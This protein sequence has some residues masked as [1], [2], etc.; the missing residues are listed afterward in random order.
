MIERQSCF[1]QLSSAYTKVHQNADFNVKFILFGG[2]GMPQTSVLGRGYC[3]ILTSISYYFYTC[4]RQ[5]SLRLPLYIKTPSIVSECYIKPLAH[6][7]ALPRSCGMWHVTS[8]DMTAAKTAAEPINW[9]GQS[10][11]V[12][13]APSNFTYFVNLHVTR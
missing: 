7:D 13:G 1:R 9:A 12:R 8:S 3:P 11:G 6:L 10:P 2:R 5:T 4:P